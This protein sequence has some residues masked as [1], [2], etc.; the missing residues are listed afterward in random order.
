MKM[1]TR[2]FVVEHK[3][4]RRSERHDDKSIWAGLDLAAVTEDV[5]NDLP[6]ERDGGEEHSRSSN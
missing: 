6:F 1:Q 3:I 2:P 5:A 4:S